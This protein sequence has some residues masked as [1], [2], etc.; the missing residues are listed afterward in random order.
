M[1]KFILK[2][3]IQGLLLAYLALFSPS[4]L[5]VVA[6]FIGV[7]FTSEVITFIDFSS[8]FRLAYVFSGVFALLVVLTYL[9]QVGMCTTIS[10]YE[11]IPL[12]NR[13]AEK[14][15]TQNY[16]LLTVLTSCFLLISSLFFILLT[17]G[18]DS[19][20]ALMAMMFL[21]GIIY[22]SLELFE[23]ESI[24]SV[25]LVLGMIFTM[26]C[27][28]HR[29]HSSIWHLVTRLAI[30]L[31]LYGL[32]NGISRVSMCKLLTSM[33]DQENLVIVS[34]VCMRQSMEASILFQTLFMI[35]AVLYFIVHCVYNSK[36]KSQNYIK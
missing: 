24:P 23:S 13:I 4:A 34:R 16:F 3:L 29:T 7:L 36:K 35:I 26:T 27:I 22:T 20:L 8:I 15:L 31:C 2:T 33:L 1:F 10:V 14:C 9:L 17:V 19:D 25:M 30:Y 5:I 11:N 21:A 6:L 18:R 32:M 28:S 12:L